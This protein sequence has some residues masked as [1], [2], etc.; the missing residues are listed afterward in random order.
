MRMRMNELLDGGGCLPARPTAS[1]LLQVALRDRTAVADGVPDARV[2]ILHMHVPQAYKLLTCA[3]RMSGNRSNWVATTSS[4]FA[5][6]APRSYVLVWPW[7]PSSLLPVRRQPST[8]ATH[9]P[10]LVR[11]HAHLNWT[12]VLSVILGAGFIFVGIPLFLG[13][14]FPLFLSF[15]CLPVPGLFFFAVGWVIVWPYLLLVAACYLMYFLWLF[16]AYYL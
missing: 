3:C 16:V 7:S 15:A 5:L 10:Q 14:G 8:M 9:S 11:H 12:D 6:F 4:P 1:A 13:V 2:H